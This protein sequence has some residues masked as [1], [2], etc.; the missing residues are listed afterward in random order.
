M[1]CDRKYFINYRNESGN[2]WL[3]IF[4]D[5]PPRLVET[6]QD[7]Y[8]KL[9]AIGSN[10]ININTGEGLKKSKKTKKSKVIKGRGMRQIDEEEEFQNRPTS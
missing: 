3:S 6:R 9:K 1:E 2:I 10:N 7:I 8:D 5:R 4:G